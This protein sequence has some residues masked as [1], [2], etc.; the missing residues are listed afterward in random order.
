[1]AIAATALSCFCVFASDIITATDKHT[2]VI[3]HIYPPTH[4]SLS[5]YL[6]SLFPA[7]IVCCIFWCKVGSLS[8]KCGIVC[9]Y[10]TLGE[11]V[12]ECDSCTRR[13]LHVIFKSQILCIIIYLSFTTFHQDSYFIFALNHIRSFQIYDCNARLLFSDL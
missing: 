1:M 2:V 3:I 10:S 12:R 6:G 11:L 8:T 4:P 13:N 5:L 7:Y 9:S